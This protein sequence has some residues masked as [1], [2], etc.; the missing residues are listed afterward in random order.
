LRR[1]E[2]EVRETLL[3]IEGAMM[4]LEELLGPE[5]PRS[6]EQNENALSE[7]VLPP[8]DA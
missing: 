8:Q 5:S 1:E 4:V 7:E 6:I 3:R 2:A